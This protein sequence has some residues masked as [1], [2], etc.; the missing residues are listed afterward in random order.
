MSLIDPE[1]FENDP[2]VAGLNQMGHATAG[3]AL[4]AVL[5][6]WLAMV[7]AALVAAALIGALELWQLRH[8]RGIAWDMFL[9][10]A[11]WSAGLLLW[12]AFLTYGL[13]TGWAVLFPLFLLGMAGAV[14]VVFMAFKGPSKEH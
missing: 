9:D 10:L 8:R 7:P 13:V 1:T 14:M 3:A 11:F 2:Y 5:S 12:W 4:V 6:I